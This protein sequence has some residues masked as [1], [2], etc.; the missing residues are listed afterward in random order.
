MKKKF[1]QGVA[2]V[3]AC[4]MIML[5]GCGGKKTAVDGTNYEFEVTM[6]PGYPVE[7]QEV[8]T[9]WI[10]I[11]KDITSKY[12]NMSE[13]PFAKMIE[14]ETGV[15][16]KFIHPPQ[17]QEASQF[18]I[19]ISSGE[20]PDIISYNWASYAN[21]GAA[22]AVRDNLIIPINTILEKGGAPALKALLDSDP[23]WKENIYTDEGWLPGFPSIGAKSQTVYYGPMIRKD[24]LDKVGKEIPETLDELDKVLYAFKDEGVKIPLE[25]LLGKDMVATNAIVGGFGIG[26]SY[27]VDENGKVKYGPAEPKFKEFL[28]LM[29]KWYNDG[30]YDQEFATLDGSGRFGAE[31]L[32]GNIGLA[33]GANGGDW[34][35][36]LPALEETHPNIEFVSMPYPSQKKGE[37]PEFGHMENRSGSHYTSISTNC[38]NKELAAKLLDWAF[39]EEG[40]LAVNYGV[41][42]RDWEYDAEGI[43]RFTPNITD[44]ALNGNQSVS[45]AMGQHTAS[46]CVGFARVQ[47]EGIL[48]VLFSRE[49]QKENVRTWTQTNM[50]AHHFPNVQYT[51]AEAQELATIK[52]AVETYMHEMLY[53][54]IGGAE[55]LDKW[56]AY[57]A[58]YKTIGLDRALEIMQ[59]AYDRYT[60][61]VK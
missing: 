29:N 16:I 1:R 7:S 3:L 11:N 2:L 51:A 12:G 40:H 10:P 45:T 37:M 19:M 52:T 38:K 43:I 4:M 55:S 5:C 47:D 49:D 57:V 56:D 9:W 42:G 48:N 15:K 13:T 21:G 44:T 28:T 27:Y 39:T 35:K 60:A 46:G 32:N 54:F 23:I 31:V 34:G 20:L 53:K 58:N 14:E 22:G 33:F 30:I 41:Q 25:V 36:W 26:A 24:L 59:N 17:G 6:A 18:N 50:E 8:L 61:R